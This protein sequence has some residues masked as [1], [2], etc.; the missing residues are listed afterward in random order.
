[1]KAKDRTGY[2]TPKAFLAVIS[3]PRGCDKWCE[4]QPGHSPHRHVEMLAEK[5]VEDRR[6]QE[7]AEEEDITE[8]RHKELMVH[9]SV[10]AM[11]QRDCQTAEARQQRE[12]QDGQTKRQLAW[13]ISRWAVTGVLGVSV[14]L[15]ASLAIE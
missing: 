4:Y 1:M 14:G 3:A 5:E 11:R 7:E 2:D 8:R 10:E 13:E 15:C 9:Q 12:W 6:A